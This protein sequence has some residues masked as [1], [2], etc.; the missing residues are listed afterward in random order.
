MPN[1][2]SA[3]KRVL[4]SGAENK[5]NVAKKTRVKNAVKKFDTA[6]ALKNVEQAEVLYKEAVSII[7][8]AQ[9]D[10]VFHAN[11]ASRKVATISRSL[12][13]LKADIAADA[14]AV[15]AARKEAEAKAA[16]AAKK[17]IADAKALGDS[18]KVAPSRKKSAKA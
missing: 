10:G 16:A 13:G 17:K 12:A 3:K 14:A 18:D 7:D 8:K 11:T 5:I 1:I 9:A 4:V 2:K 6:I 15:E